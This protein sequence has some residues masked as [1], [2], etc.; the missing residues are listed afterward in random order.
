[1]DED[2][3]DILESLPAP[4]SPEIFSN[5]SNKYTEAEHQFAMESAAI[6]L[7]RHLNISNKKLFAIVGERVC[8][9]EAET[10]FKA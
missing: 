9:T 5:G 2:I 3:L 6:I 7:K 10:M 1:M 4:P 8:L